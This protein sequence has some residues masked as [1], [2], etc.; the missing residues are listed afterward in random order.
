M[1]DCLSINNLAGRTTDELFNRGLLSHI[2]FSIT[3][4]KVVL[5][6]SS[7]STP[8]GFFSPIVVVFFFF[9]TH[10]FGRHQLG[11]S[12]LAVESL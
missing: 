1:E 12:L 6:K 2:F 5:Q 4:V 10:P 11:C 9:H 8:D 3:K 7:E